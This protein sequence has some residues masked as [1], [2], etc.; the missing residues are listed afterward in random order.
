MRKILV[1][2]LLLWSVVSWAQP[3]SVPKYVTVNER[4]NQL[5]LIA[6]AL[7]IPIMGTPALGTNQ[8][9]LAGAIIIDTTGGNKGMHG[10]W[11]GVW[12]RIV[13][14]TYSGLTTSATNG[15][16]TISSHTIGLGGSALSQ[17]SS[18]ELSGG[19]P[20]TINRNGLNSSTQSDSNSIR[21]TNNT[22][23]TTTTDSLVS[24]RLILQIK[25][26][27]SIGSAA[28][29]KFALDAF[30]AGGF[31][32]S[33]AY[34]RWRASTNSGT[35]S[36]IFAISNIN[37]STGIS[38][39]IPMQ[40]NL[41][42]SPIGVPP[43]STVSSNLAWGLNTMVH[44]PV[45]GTS[46]IA[47]GGSAMLVHNYGNENV[48]IGASA[49]AAQDSVDYNTAIGSYALNANTRGFQNTAV[50]KNAMLVNTTGSK[51]TSVGAGSMEATTTGGFNTAI[52]HDALL[53]NTTGTDNVAHGWLGWAQ[54]ITGNYN[55]GIGN[56]TGRNITNG[57]NNIYI[58][59]EAGYL[60][61]S[62]INRQFDNI[63]HSI[64]IGSNAWATASYQTVLG[65]D[66]TTHT[67]IRGDI[68]LPDAQ[69]T[70][71]TSDSV[72]VIKGGTI[73]KIA[74]IGAALNSQY[75]DV[76][77]VG[78]GED[79]LMTYSVPAGQLA[80]NGDYLEFE[81]EVQFFGANTKTLKVYFGSQGLLS[82]GNSGTSVGFFTVKGTIVR[83]GATT[84]RCN[85]HVVTSSATYAYTSE[86]TTPSET[87]SGA[88]I[89]KFTGTAT[90][91]N[92]IVQHMMWVK[93]FP[94]N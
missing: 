48:A 70:G 94:G 93:Y 50:G 64:V 24:P 62:G 55:V 15:T 8:P 71:T 80:T 45:T 6:R 92:D 4:R 5:A 82:T 78:A 69:A 63:H 7:N 11:D 75:T 43:F 33:T 13:D 72:L 47:I 17:Y 32:T 35:E 2:G 29:I 20:L 23:A 51:N 25:N 39:L 66:S 27:P 52:G 57:S 18:I 38:G 42:G 30:G 3:S 73:K 1:F 87:L 22:T 65:N 86:Y 19:F 83:T 46:N 58:G 88:I 14:T 31:S 49:L 85:V 61:M 91:D 77:N 68:R 10:Y 41:S 21:L 12:H 90:S 54:N 76:G 79:N 37:A 44:N 26:K 28:P 16:S 59:H 67:F 56:S 84:Q 89:L 74:P 9:G 34:I 53:H 36:T 60:D 40:L 81:G